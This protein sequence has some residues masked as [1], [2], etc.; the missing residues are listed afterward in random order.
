MWRL[1]LNKLRFLLH[2]DR[3]DRDLAEELDFHRE[4]L[5]REKR[6]SGLDDER[7]LR[8]ARLQLGNLDVA[9]EDAREV[10]L[11]AWLE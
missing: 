11:F 3:F 1:V 2:R 9:R 8:A 10:W 7:A 4:M 5:E 6:Q